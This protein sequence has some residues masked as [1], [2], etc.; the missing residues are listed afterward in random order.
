MDTP[1][2]F[3]QERFVFE[4]LKDQNASAAAAR[5]GYT[6]KNM[7]AQGSELIS[8]PAIRERVRMELQGLL[9]EIDCSPLALMQE[10][11]RAAFFRAGNMLG[12]GWELLAPD[13][14]EPETR[15]ALEVTTVMRKSGPEVRLKQPDRDRALRALERVHERLE[16]LNEAHYAKLERQGEV[17]SLAQV[18]ALDGGEEAAAAFSQ[19]PKVLS[20]SA[21]PPANT[22]V[23]AE[24]TAA[25]APFAIAQNPGVLSDCEAAATMPEARISAKPPVLSGPPPTGEA[26]GSC[27]FS[28]KHKVLSG[29]SQRTAPAMAAA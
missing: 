28:E 26:S 19:K 22:S 18:E 12:P 27:V 15:A 7:A 3:R 21:P 13:Q 1:L 10:R 11:M 16:K 29:A 4:Y 9:A 25:A 24:A 14:M 2:T 6:A 5:A 17:K 20:G 23:F 8:N